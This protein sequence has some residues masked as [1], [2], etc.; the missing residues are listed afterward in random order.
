MHH[1]VL[2]VPDGYITAW[3]IWQLHGDTEAAKAF[4]GDSLEIIDHCVPLNQKNIL[5]D[6]MDYIHH[7]L[8]SKPESS[9]EH[10]PP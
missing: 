6:G 3:F 7:Q 4:I 9:D 5:M 2:Y 1:E 10:I 8:Y